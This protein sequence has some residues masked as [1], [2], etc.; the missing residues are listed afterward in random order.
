MKL[1]QIEVDEG[2]NVDVDD[3]T[4]ESTAIELRQR[5]STTR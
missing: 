1:L 5:T 2:Q 4:V 3:V